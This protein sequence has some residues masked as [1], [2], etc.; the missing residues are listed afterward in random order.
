MRTSIIENQLFGTP[1]PWEGE[2]ICDNHSIEYELCGCK[3]E[4]NE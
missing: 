2:D 4:N 1:L 3:K